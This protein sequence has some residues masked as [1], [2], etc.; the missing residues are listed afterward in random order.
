L[1]FGPSSFARERLEAL[2]I[3][4]IEVYLKRLAHGT[5]LYGIMT[6]MVNRFMMRLAAWRGATTPVA[7]AGRP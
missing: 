6:K 1:R 2:E 4:V 7:L 5:R 3:V